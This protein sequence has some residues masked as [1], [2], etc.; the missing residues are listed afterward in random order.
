MRFILNWIVTS[1][2]VSIA[3][4]LVGG[5]APYGAVE[6]WVAFASTGLFLGIVNWLIKPVI[7]FISLPI[8]FLTLGIF[9]L[10]VNGFMLSLAGWLSVNLFGAGIVIADF[11]S[12]F[13]GAIIV[14]I[15]CSILGVLTKD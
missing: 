8:T 11:W 3:A 9:Q 10:V 14:S 4:A 15:M 6:P 7:S 1:I 2:A 5:I 12:A 13:L